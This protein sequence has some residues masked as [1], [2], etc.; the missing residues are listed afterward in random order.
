M[1][2]NEYRAYVALMLGQHESNYYNWKRQGRPIIAFLEKY[3]T[4]EDVKEF[5]EN[6][7][8]GWLDR[9]IQQRN[10]TSFAGISHEEIDDAEEA[11][12]LFLKDPAAG[13]QKIDENLK[14]AEMRKLLK[15]LLPEFEDEIV[16]RVKYE[17]FRKLTGG[18][19]DD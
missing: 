6:G 8:I 2:K 10:S 13:L 16:D 12:E 7:K 18:G 19:G 4:G 17:I 11:G 14:K 1:K 5:L 9:A 3:M 15:E